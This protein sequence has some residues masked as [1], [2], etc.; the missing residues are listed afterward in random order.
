MLGGDDSLNWETAE[1]ARSQSGHSQVCEHCS[2]AKYLLVGGV[3]LYNRE[4]RGI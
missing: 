2:G 3:N 1:I 4:E